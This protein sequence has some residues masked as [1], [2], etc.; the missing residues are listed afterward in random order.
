M[1]KVHSPINVS[2]TMA[3]HSRP[4]FPQLVWYANP[5]RGEHRRNVSWM[6]PLMAELHTE[7][8][9]DFYHPDRDQAPWHVQATINGHLCNFW[10][11]AGKMNVDGEKT[12]YGRTHVQTKC[13][14]L[15]ANPPEQFEVIEDEQDA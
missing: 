6:R 1:D 3:G 7:H 10:P 9:V 8:G 14:D 4:P 13:M 15:L 5:R 11:C 2:G 12:V